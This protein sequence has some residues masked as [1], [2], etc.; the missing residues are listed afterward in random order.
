MHSGATASTAVA[1][2]IAGVAL[3]ASG[4]RVLLLLVLLLSRVAALRVGD[5]LLEVR[6]AAV[7][8]RFVHANLELAVS[9]D[10]RVAAVV[11][12][13]EGVEVVAVMV[14]GAARSFDQSVDH[15]DQ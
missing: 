2:F 13:E 12:L 4:R 15:N 14:L 6:L 7:H 8:P 1:V 9:G 11:V 5:R 10:G 3:R